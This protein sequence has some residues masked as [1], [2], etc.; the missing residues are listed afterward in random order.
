MG[1]KSSGS[2]ETVKTVLQNYQLIAKYMTPMTPMNLCLGNNNRT[3]I[4]DSKVHD[5]TE[6]KLFLI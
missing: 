5:N 2:A 6:G 1:T 4:A 3:G